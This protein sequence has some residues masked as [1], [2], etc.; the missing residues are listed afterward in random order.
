[1]EKNVQ[2]PLSLLDQTID[3]FEDLDVSDFSKQTRALYDDIF[4]AF[5]EKKMRICLRDSYSKIINANTDN[6]RNHARVEY[7]INKRFTK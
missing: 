5:I 7:L 3:F 1:M 4:S 2:I 6:E